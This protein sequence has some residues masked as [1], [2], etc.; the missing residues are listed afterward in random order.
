MITSGNSRTILLIIPEEPPFLRELAQHTL[1]ITNS[2]GK[3]LFSVPQ[4]HG[5]HVTQLHYNGY[6]KILYL[7]LHAFSIA[8]FSTN[9]NILYPLRLFRKKPGTYLLIQYSQPLFGITP[10]GL[11]IL[12]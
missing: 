12:L 6:L 4:R 11:E 2:A 10:V 5:T 9:E 7:Q 3:N 8:N 1:Q